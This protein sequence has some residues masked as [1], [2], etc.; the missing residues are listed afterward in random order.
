MNTFGQHADEWLVTSALVVG[1]TY[2]LMKWKG[3]TQTPIPTFAT[4]W[5]CVYL[6]LALVTQASPQ[7][8]GSFSVLVMTGDLLA[9]GQKLA[10]LTKTTPS[11]TVKTTTTAPAHKAA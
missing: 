1:G 2:V 8:G 3:L 11:S 6:V 10:G 5:G 9:N 7:F 4:A